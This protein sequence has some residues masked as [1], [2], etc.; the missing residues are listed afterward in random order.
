MKSDA[1]NHFKAEMEKRGLFRKIQV[2]ANLIPPPPGADGETLIEL[3]RSA[4]KIAIQNYAEHHEYFCDVMAEAA[5]DHL[6]NTVLSDDLFIPNGG[7]SP[8]KEEV[9]NMNRAKET[10]DKAAKMLDTLFGGL[11]DL[12]KTL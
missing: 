12:L 7:F 3:H 9:D 10:T 2:C 6:L 5:I 4:A 11:A 8:T 1:L